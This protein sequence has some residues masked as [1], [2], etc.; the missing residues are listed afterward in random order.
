M[1]ELIPRQPFPN[2]KFINRLYNK[3]RR[4]SNV[5]IFQSGLAELPAYGQDPNS[6]LIDGVDVTGHLQL[7]AEQAAVKGLARYE[8]GADKH[9]LRSCANT[10][11]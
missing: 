9:D 6:M 1:L 2:D 3:A 10:V 8:P 4:A 5:Q 11:S 7:L